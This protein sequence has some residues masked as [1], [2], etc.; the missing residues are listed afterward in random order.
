MS[1]ILEKLKVIVCIGGGFTHGR[2]IRR[3]QGRSWRGRSLVIKGMDVAESNV[4]VENSGG[5]WRT[6]CGC[7]DP[8]YKGTN[9]IER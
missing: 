4:M 5:R 1:S 8:N 6:R 7:L 2:W 3:D 9:E